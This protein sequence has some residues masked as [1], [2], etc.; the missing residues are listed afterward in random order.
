MD[1]E[2]LL[3]RE[4]IIPLQSIRAVTSLLKTWLHKLYW[5]EPG[6]GDLERVGVDLA[7]PP[8]KRAPDV[9]TATALS[10]GVQV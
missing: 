2:E 10:F 9:A 3:E 7:K 4:T 5:C 8:S 1:D 6:V